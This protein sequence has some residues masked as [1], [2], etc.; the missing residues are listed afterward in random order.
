MI[1]AEIYLHASSVLQLQMMQGADNL[2]DASWSASADRMMVETQPEDSVLQ[3]FV[4]TI[5]RM[6]EL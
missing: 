5:V 6:N 1:E 3:D 4:L 2:L